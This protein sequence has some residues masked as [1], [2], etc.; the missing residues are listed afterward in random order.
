MTRNIFI[1]THATLAQGFK[2]AARLIAGTSADDITAFCL[3]EGGSADDFAKEANDYIGAHP[4][5]EVVILTDLFGA[6]LFNAMSVL[7]NH[8]N[9]FVFAGTNLSLVIDLLLDP[10]PLD[11]SVIE[12]KLNLCKEGLMWLDGMNQDVEEEDF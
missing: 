1:A 2:D 3:L 11:A 6:S 12:E 7:S 10:T 9:V 5:Q 4:E 8:P